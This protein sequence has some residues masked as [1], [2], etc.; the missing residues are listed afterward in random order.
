MNNTTATVQNIWI[1]FCNGYTLMT[2]NTDYSNTYTDSTGYHRIAIKAQLSNGDIVET[3]TAVMV[4]V[5]NSAN[6]YTNADLANPSFVIH[7]DGNQNGCKVY[8]RRSIA[9]PGSQILRPFIVAEGLDIHDGAPAIDKTNYNVNALLDE[10]NNRFFNGA[11]INFNFDDIGH[12]DLVFID[13]NNGVDDI[14]CNAITM[15]RVNRHG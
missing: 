11:D 4:Q 12:Y 14:H 15:E 9:T 1:N 5:I 3:Y 6:R 2:A 13:W 8:I 7:A 10:W